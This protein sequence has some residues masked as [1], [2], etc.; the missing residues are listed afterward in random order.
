M[1]EHVRSWIQEWDLRRL[2]PA[3]RPQIEVERIEA[4]YTENPALEEPS[5][6]EAPDAEP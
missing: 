3:Y 4:D 2:D 6:G 1:R 5:D